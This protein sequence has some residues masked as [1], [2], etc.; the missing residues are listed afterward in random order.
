MISLCTPTRNR[1]GPFKQ[2]CLSVLNNASDPDSIEFVVYRDNDDESAYEYVGN[3]K[4]IR[5]KRLYADPSINQC[6]KIATGPI[7]IFMPDDIIFETKGWDEQV[8][9]A[10]DKSADKIIF[11]YF[12]DHYLRSNYGSIGCLHKNWVD[13]VGYFLNPNLCRAGDHWINLVARS[14]NRMVYI[15]GV[16]YRDQRI[17]EDQTHKEFLVEMERSK[18]EERY[19]SESMK[20]ERA[21]NA[22]LLQKFIDNFKTG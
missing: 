14:I 13:T 12:N 2:M 5:G 4:E 10:F 22:Q 15:N 16:G 6:Q 11:V 9:D 1:P 18:Y 3:Y 20:T 21:K 17:I 19:D 8:K 7:Y